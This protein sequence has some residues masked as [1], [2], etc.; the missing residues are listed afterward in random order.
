M[1][2]TR[3]PPECSIRKRSGGSVGM[4]VRAAMN[5]EAEVN[6]AERCHVFTHVFQ[7]PVPRL[8]ELL[9]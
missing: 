1:A 7:P 8:Y 9:P 6:A 2:N 5:A 3:E 4:G